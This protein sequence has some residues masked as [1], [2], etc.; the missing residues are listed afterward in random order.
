M[1]Q[2]SAAEPRAGLLPPCV[3]AHHGQHGGLAYQLHY[4]VQ[5]A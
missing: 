3:V 2:P 1:G 4:R 5:A